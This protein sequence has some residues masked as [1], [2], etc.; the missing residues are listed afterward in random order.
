MLFNSFDF[1]V[2]LPI[3]LVVYYCLAR[4]AQNVFL[5]AASYVF[6][7]WWDWRFCA[8][9]ALSTVLDYLCGL[10]VAREGRRRRV[11]LWASVVGNLGVLAFFKY[12]DFFAGSAADLLA[13]FGM[14]ADL[15]TL[16]I[17]LPIMHE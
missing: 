1:L 2:F 8:L 15:P 17:V 5:L 7:G 13:R 9:I 6:Y 14:A 3:V 11:F 4:Q 16:R 10:G 12:F